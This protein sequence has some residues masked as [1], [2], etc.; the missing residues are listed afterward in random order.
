VGQDRTTPG[1]KGGVVGITV[2]CLLIATAV[3]LFVVTQRHR[4]A[5]NFQIGAPFPAPCTSGDGF[6]CYD[7]RVTNV[8]DLSGSIECTVTDT[9]AGAASFVNGD[10]TYH[11][12]PIEPGREVFV[13]V[14]VDEPAGTDHGTASVPDA[15][16]AGVPAS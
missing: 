7:I 2:L 15:Q 4:P 12:A 9:D 5:A 3:V 13:I 6:R 10:H 1:R 16:C 14:Q 11:S 8:G